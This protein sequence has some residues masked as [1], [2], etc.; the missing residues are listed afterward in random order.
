MTPK[1]LGRSKSCPDSLQSVTTML[2]WAMPSRFWP[3]FSSHVATFDHSQCPILN[4]IRSQASLSFRPVCCSVVHLSQQH[5]EPLACCPR[6]ESPY[7]LGCTGRGW[8]LSL[9]AWPTRRRL[10]RRSPVGGRSRCTP[11]SGPHFEARSEWKEKQDIG[12]KLNRLRLENGL[13]MGGCSSLGVFND[14]CSF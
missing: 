6:C 4:K 11:G 12:S 13:T 3:R 5:W 2:I 8:R 14:W 1:H 9:P 10:A 7:F